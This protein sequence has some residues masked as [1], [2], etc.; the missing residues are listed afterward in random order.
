M[1]K[2]YRLPLKTSKFSNAVIKGKQAPGARGWSHKEKVLSLVERGGKVCSTHVQHVNAETLRPILNEQIAAES[3]LMTDEARVYAPLGKDF[4]EHH[5]VNHG[6]G[7]DHTNTIEGYFSIFKRGM[8]GV[9][10]HCSGRHLKRY[11][12][13]YDFRYNE[14][15]ALGVNDLERADTALKDIQGKRLTYQTANK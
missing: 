8:K 12:A 9:Y 6:I 15:D 14:R 10:Q 3:R 1:G 13:E 7:D 11:L 4:A 5:S 2:H